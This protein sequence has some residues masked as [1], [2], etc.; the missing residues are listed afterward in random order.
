[1]YNQEI[2]MK[3]ALIYNQE[4]KKYSFGKGHPFTSDRFEN[5]LAF[6][7]QKLP[8]FNNFFELIVPKPAKDKDLEL[9]HSKEYIEAM[10]KASK[11][12]IL[13]NIF[14][15]TTTD[16]LDPSTG[17][18]P[19]GI[20]KAGKIA[21]GSSLKAAELVFKGK[22]KKAISLGG[23][24]HHAKKQ[25]G[26][27]FCIYNDVVIS[28]KAL[29]KKGIKRVLIL[30]TDAHAGNGTAEAF[31]N[32]NEV[33]FIDMHQDP[34]TVYPGTGFIHEIGEGK[35]KGFTINISLPPGASDKSY[36]YAFDKIIF[37]VVKEFKPEIIIRNGGSDPHFA[38]G[39]TNLGLTLNGFKMIGEKVRKLANE[40]CGGKEIDLIA[41]GY[42]QKILPS[43]WLSL[44]SG[45][46][47]LSIEIK[48]DKKVFPKKDF[49]LKETKNV[50]ENLKSHLKNHWKCF[51]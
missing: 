35:G 24:L 45:L 47:N 51:R 3:T 42:N 32:E 19:K 2:S 44:I 21:V 11:G 31:Y 39:L 33:L 25:K 34:R 29:L 13:P 48:E 20:D 38:D 14:Q 50:I 5:F 4:I 40:V 18:L 37:P 8:D 15:Y 7:K 6:L 26:E 23:G 46:C 27:G 12:I 1:M 17:Y 10:K 30:D 36:E 16:N 43:A 28:A 41:S 9:F 22:F 49:R